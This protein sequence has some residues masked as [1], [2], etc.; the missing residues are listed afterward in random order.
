MGKNYRAAGY[1]SVSQMVDRM[2]SAESEHLAAFVRFVQADTA[3]HQALK[4]KDWAG[5]AKRYNGRRYKDNDY[6]AKMAEAYQRNLPP[7]TPG[8]AAPGAIG[9]GPLP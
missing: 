2:A 5:F 8:G 9:P 4:A 3:M 7:A 1:N 6:D